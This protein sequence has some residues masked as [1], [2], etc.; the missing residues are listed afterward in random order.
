MADTMDKWQAQQ[1]FWSGFGLTAYDEMTVPDD[2][3]M[4]YITYEAVAGNIGAKTQV[5]ASLWYRSNSWQEIC[6]KADLIAATIS[7]DERPAIKIDNGYM[8]VRVPDGVM[9]SDR[10]DE[11]TDSSV[12]RI[13][14]V[15]ELEFLT[16]Y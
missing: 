16:R 11:P 15:V 6:K 1:S 13:R 8:M 10:M 14:F 7:A 5:S 2:A 9:H 4:P 3:V 12:R